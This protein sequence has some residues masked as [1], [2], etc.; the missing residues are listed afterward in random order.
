MQIGEA[1][2][3]IYVDMATHRDRAETVRLRQQRL[4]A[5]GDRQCIRKQLLL[6]TQA[7]AKAFGWAMRRPVIAN[8][9]LVEMDVAFDECGKD[10]KPRQ[11]DDVGIGRQRRRLNKLT[12]R[13]RQIAGSTIFQQ[14]VSI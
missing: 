9:A 14:S 5:I 7:F 13:H 6:D 11:V 12:A 1:D 3:G 4:R 10:Q 8:E 2:R